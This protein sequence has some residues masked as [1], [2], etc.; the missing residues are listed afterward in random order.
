MEV[1]E[2]DC[3]IYLGTCIAPKGIAKNG[4][5]ICHYKLVGSGI[6]QSGELHFGDLIRI[7]L[8]ADATCTVELTPAKSFDVGN[9]PG[10]TLMKKVHGGTVGIILDG[11]GR[12]LELPANRTEC[13][14][15]VRRWNQAMS[16]YPELKAVG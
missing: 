3:L 14:T 16:M 13:R 9:G 12:P 15:T 8:D 7:P 6:D 5:S 4:Q 10:R 1:F 2:R 11:R